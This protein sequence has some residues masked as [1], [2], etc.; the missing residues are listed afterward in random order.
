MKRYTLCLTA[1]IVWSMLLIAPPVRAQDKDTYTAVFVVPAGTNSLGAANIVEL[2]NTGP[3]YSEWTPLSVLQNIGTATGAASTNTTNL[4]YRPRDA[5]KSYRIGG[6]TAQTYGT[7]ALA[8]LTSYPPLK[9][10][11]KLELQ[12]TALSNLTY[13]VT[14]EVSARR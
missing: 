11:D 14:Y 1:L 13:F 2:E 12:G 7:E 3:L 8:V 5:V 10:G 4:A 9:N 6:V